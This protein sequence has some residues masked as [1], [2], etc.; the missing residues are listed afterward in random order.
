MTAMLALQKLRPHDIVQVDKSVPR[1]PLV[2]EGL[3]AGE[4]VEAWKLMYALLLY[5]GNDDASL[6]RSQQAV[7]SG[8][9]SRR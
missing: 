4:Q 7:T 2:R 6:S 5:S 3:R 9:S 1:V 8:S